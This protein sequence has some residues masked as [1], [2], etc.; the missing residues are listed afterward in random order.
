MAIGVLGT[1]AT[2]LQAFQ[3]AIGVAGH[4]IANA[5][6]EG[7][8]RQRVELGTRPPTFT[9]QGYIGNGV[10]VT[11]IERLY[12]Q[13][14]TER[15]RDTTSSSAQYQTLYEMAARVSNLLGDADAG[16]NAGLADFFN[17]VQGVADDPSSVPARQVL[18]SEADSLAGRL[19][20]LDSQLESLRQETT[21]SIE[22]LVNEINSL[23]AGIADANRS[24]VDAMA[25]GA[26]RAPNDLMDERDRMIDRLSELVSVRTVEQDDG[27]INVFIGTGQPL[28]T[29]FLPSTLEV[30]PNDMDARRAEIAIRTGGSAAVVTGFITGGRLG[31]ALDFRDQVLNPAQNALGR[32]AA[33][34][35][36]EFNRQH[37]LG[38]DL[39][40]APGGDFFRNG[41][42]EVLDS[43]NNTGAASV[44]ASFDESAIDALTTDDYVLSYDGSAWTLTRA[45]TN[46][47]VA[48]SGSGTA[49]D[50]FLADGL[51]IEVSGAAAA[52]DRFMIR[53]TR[54]VS[55]VFGLALDD[56]RAV[57]AAA[58]VQ[59]GEALDADGKP[60]NGGD[61]R[62]R[63]QSVA[64]GF[65]P[66]AGDITFT[67]DAANNRF[68]YSGAASG[69]ITYDPASNA[70][71]SYTVAG[72]TFTITGTPADNDQFVAGTGSGRVSDNGN[73][74]L[75]AD[76]QSALTM[77]GGSASFQD[78]YGQLV[79]DIGTRT[80][81]AQIT[82]QAQKA[83]REQAQESRD[84]VS[85]VNL[86]E[87]AANLLRFQQAYQALAQLISVAD[88]TFQTL[89]SAVGR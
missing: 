23:S 34:L 27:A 7:Y 56:T 14:V 85:G 1:A 86:D 33:T 24:I 69:S 39:D 26:G 75:L 9:G 60:L 21:S 46:Q 88:T 37:R 55:A 48:M 57:A 53:P 62:F 16:L 11:G 10:Q 78:A 81:S 30:Q 18:L 42:P 36:V 59:I 17:A 71:D 15:L 58:P 89:L 50:P 54:G 52:G 87:E 77:E 65:T 67:Y 84:A 45:G 64:D 8:T 40:G 44:S 73:A 28:V 13:F 32:V 82:A 79:G 20:H 31:A 41:A 4:N 66:P 5:N 38:T 51:R 2:G 72:I 25:Q 63:F 29:R 74:L 49:A 80:R 61:A 12:D 47:A 70:G 6:T 68:D 3:R 22:T 83:L 76:L 43:R 35:A 19:R